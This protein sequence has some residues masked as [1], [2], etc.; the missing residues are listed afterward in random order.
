MGIYPLSFL[1]FMSSSS[2][3][4]YIPRGDHHAIER[5]VLGV[6]S[7]RE[8]RD[9]T[10]GLLKTFLA[11]LLQNTHLPSWL[12][13][14]HG[15]MTENTHLSETDSSGSPFV[16]KQTWTLRLGSFYPEDPRSLDSDVE[17]LSYAT[18]DFCAGYMSDEKC[19]FRFPLS[20]L[21]EEAAVTGRKVNLKQLGYSSPRME[22]FGNV[23]FMM[24]IQPKDE[25]TL[26]MMESLGATPNDQDDVFLT[27]YL[28]KGSSGM[29]PNGGLFKELAARRSSPPPPQHHVE[30]L[31]QY[32]LQKV[33]PK[34]KNE[35]YLKLRTMQG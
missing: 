6:S 1:H 22:R 14:Y 8:P 23:T 16:P 2:E 15:E 34:H 19:L 26:Q 13:R 11:H 27:F 17:A 18:V 28:D 7:H 5:A 24:K 29:D 4:S 12:G 9:A 33:D 10:T 20:K 31:H 32:L 21:A 35:L 25:K 3:S 30:M